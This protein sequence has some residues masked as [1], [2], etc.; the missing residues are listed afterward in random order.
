[1]ERRKGLSEK[2]AWATGKGGKLR[3]GEKYRDFS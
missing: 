2:E 3:R 1:V